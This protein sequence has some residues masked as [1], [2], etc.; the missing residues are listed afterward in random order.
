VDWITDEERWRIAELVAE[1]GQPEPE[2]T[3]GIPG[4]AGSCGAAPQV[5][6]RSRRRADIRGQA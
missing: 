5:A 3:E 1:G 2:F 6:W 4:L